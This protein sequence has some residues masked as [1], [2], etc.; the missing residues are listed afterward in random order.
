MQGDNSPVNFQHLDISEKVSAA[1]ADETIA[2]QPQAW[3]KPVASMAVAASVAAAVVIG[4]QGVNPT[5]QGFQPGADSSS[6]TIASNT[7]PIISLG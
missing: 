6:Q 5:G 3:W 1:I 7:P 4:V 2:K